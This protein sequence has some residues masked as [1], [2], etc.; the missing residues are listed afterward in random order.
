MSGLSRAVNYK[1]SAKIVNLRNS[2]YLT[3]SFKKEKIMAYHSLQA[4]NFKQL[5]FF[6]GQ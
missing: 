3:F 2:F 4:L 5:C 6:G 1:C